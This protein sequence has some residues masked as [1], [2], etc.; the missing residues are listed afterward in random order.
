MNLK[1]IAVLAGLGFQTSWAAEIYFTDPVAGPASFV[2]KVNH[3]GSGFQT[4]GPA[5]HPRGMALDPVG[6]KIYWADLGS[7]SIRRS[8]L[9]GS[10]AEFV[11]QT[12]DTASGVAIDVGGRKLYW[13]TG[14]QDRR[15]RR[16][17]LDGSDAQDVITTGVANAASVAI[18]PVHGKLYWSD[19]Q[20]HRDGTGSIWW[21]NL[22]GSNPQLLLNA[23]DEPAGLAC[24]AVGGKLYWAENQ[25]QKIQSAN[26]DGSNVQ[27]LV[28][29]L[30]G[31]TTV[32]LDLVARKIYWTEAEP[33]SPTRIQRSDLNGAS[34]EL[35]TAEAG[36]P[37][38]IAVLP[39]PSVRLVRAVKPAFSGLTIGSRYQLQTSGDLQTWTD[40]GEPFI[41]TAIDM[42]YPA[43]WDVENWEALHFRLQI[44]E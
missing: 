18:D 14:L 27:D 12:D 35:V 5:S 25:T 19:L 36:F 32:A 9:D 24:D 38:G 40:H 6:R 43:Y 13:T 20:G 11:I 44:I 29:G 8:N 42:S 7:G 10:A 33:G 28:T 1:T 39:G 15:I 2:R 37:W 16:A 3:D 41:S 22:D 23:I 21:S 34:V 30:F 4:L 31:P 17:N 26:L